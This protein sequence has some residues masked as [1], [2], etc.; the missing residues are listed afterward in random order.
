MHF[1]RYEKPL[2]AA[3]AAWL[4]VVRLQYRAAPCTGSASVIPWPLP[5][6]I[7]IIARD[8]EGSFNPNPNGILN[9]TGTPGT[10][11]FYR[12]DQSPYSGPCPI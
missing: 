5:C 9:Y 2:T 10:G 12:N 4:Y 3:Q 11:G 6:L 8:P 1:G 7:G